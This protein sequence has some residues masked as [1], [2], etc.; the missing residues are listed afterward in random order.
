MSSPKPRA[1]VQ[2]DTNSHVARTPDPS[3]LVGS[4]APGCPARMV[5][6]W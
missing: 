3:D 1:V 6:A 5:V 4:G 2:P